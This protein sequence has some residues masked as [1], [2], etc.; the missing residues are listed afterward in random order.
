[1]FFLGLLLVATV[2]ASSD[3][4][5]ERVQKLGLAYKD[6]TLGER[7]PEADGLVPL[8][9]A[10]KG[11]LRYRKGSLI[12]AVEEKTRRLIAL[13]EEYPALKPEDL[14]KLISSLMAQFGEP[15]F[16]AHEKMLFWYYSSRGKITSEAF[17]HLREEGKEPEVLAIAKFYCDQRIVEFGNKKDSG[18]KA[19]A[20]FTLYSPLLIRKFVYDKI[21]YS[22][23]KF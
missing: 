13:Y 5:F 7:L 3:P 6:F 9:D 23:K 20:F 18:G 17:E 15:T 19:K 4:D 14:Q 16:E 12:L 2:W 10:F 1:M 21:D 22:P 8:K 11:T